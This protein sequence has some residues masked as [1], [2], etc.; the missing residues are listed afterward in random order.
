MAAILNEA[1][2]LL[3]VVLAIILEVKYPTCNVLDLQFIYLLVQFSRTD[4][5]V[6]YYLESSS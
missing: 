1:E 6:S 5:D 3:S 2:Q 4:Q